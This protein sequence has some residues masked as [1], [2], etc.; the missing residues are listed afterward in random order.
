MKLYRFYPSI[1]DKFKSFLNL[2]IETFWWQDERG[3]W[4]RNYD[5]NSGEYHYSAS[6]V[7][8]LAKQELIDAIN[9]VPFSSRAANMGTAFNN[10]VDYVIN[11]VNTSGTPIYIYD[12]Y[13]STTLDD[14]ELKYDRNFIDGVAEYLKGSSSQIFCSA[15]ITTRYGVVTL[16]GYIDEIQRDKVIDLKFSKKY[17]FGNYKDG[18]QRHVYPYCLTEMGLVADIKEFEYCCY[19][20]NNAEIL[21][22]VQFREVYTYNHEDSKK[23]IREVCEKFIEFLEENRDKITDKKIFANG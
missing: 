14:E 11:G 2:D 7:E 8:E 16:Y 19:Q 10:I 12:T 5:E 3:G 23:C 4:H 15:D 1:L 17:D 20:H 6:E 22:G 18:M 21:N 9:R 13:Y